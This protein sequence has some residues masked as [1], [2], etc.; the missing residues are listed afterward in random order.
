MYMYAKT[1]QMFIFFTELRPTNPIDNNNRNNILPNIYPGGS[2][3]SYR[4]VRGPPIAPINLMPPV[5]PFK[6]PDREGRV[7]VTDALGRPQIRPIFGPDSS[8]GTGFMYMGFTLPSPPEG[9]GQPP[10]PQGG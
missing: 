9:Q 3:P 4:P 10:R 2:H 5:P 6:L 7:V 8:K 1:S